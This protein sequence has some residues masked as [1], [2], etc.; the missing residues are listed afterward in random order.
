[1]RL[2]DTVRSIAPVSPVRQNLTRCHA[3]SGP[4]WTSRGGKL[5]SVQVSQGTPRTRTTATFHKTRQKGDSE[6]KEQ[7]QFIFTERKRQAGLESFQSSTEVKEEEE[8]VARFGLCNFIPLPSPSSLHPL[9]SPP[10]LPLLT[11]AILASFRLAVMRF[12]N[13]EERKKQKQTEE[14]TVRERWIRPRCMA[15]VVP[16][17]VVVRDGVVFRLHPPLP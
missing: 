10:R 2:P 7:Q 12:Q 13:T 5:S 15:A 14:G 11:R 3:S 17:F 16:W 8:R 6:T 4:T 1:M 9:P